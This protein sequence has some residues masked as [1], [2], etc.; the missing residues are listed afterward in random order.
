MAE[1]E[2]TEFSS[3]A[4]GN[5][6]WFCVKSQPKHEHIA[7]A[8]LRKIAEIDVF[9]PRIRFKRAM[10]RGSA[11]V[12]EALFPGYLFAR[13]D[14]H[15]KLRQIHH[16]HGV[17]GVVH[18]GDRWPSIP[19][20]TLQELRK[21]IGDAELCT[22]GTAL[23]PGDNV[24]VAEGALKGLRAVV[25]HVMPARERVA[26]LMEFLGRQTMIELPIN[27]IV[28]EGDKRHEILNQK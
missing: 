20:G 13:F 5:A 25:A 10:R 8:H 4:S 21:N 6:V 7:A 19:E 28:T 3:K 2:N 14:W 18:F 12:T 11:W 23:A 22:V 9:L 26:V 17:R 16:A 15:S 27:T 24:Q 1:N